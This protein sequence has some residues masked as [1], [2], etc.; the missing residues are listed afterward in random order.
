MGDS[1]TWSLVHSV[2]RSLGPFCAMNG[3]LF[4]FRRFKI[5]LILF[6]TSGSFIDADN[7][8]A[9]EVRRWA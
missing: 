6:G 5:I 4:R 7:E 9:L 8:K 1:V 3:Q 2:T